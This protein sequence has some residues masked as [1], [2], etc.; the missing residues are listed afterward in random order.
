MNHGKLRFL[1]VITGCTAL[2]VGS[3]TSAQTPTVAIGFVAR[4]RRTE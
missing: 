1:D 2:M 4:N 3:I